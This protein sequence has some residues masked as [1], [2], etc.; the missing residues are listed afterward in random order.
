MNAVSYV[1]LFRTKRKARGHALKTNICSTS[2]LGIS[3]KVTVAEDTDAVFVGLDFCRELNKQGF[4]AVKYD[5][6]AYA[7][8]EW[9]MRR[10]VTLTKSQYFSLR[11][12][13]RLLKNCG[14]RKHD[15]LELEGFIK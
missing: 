6:P 12:P 1:I 15:R 10:E 8:T 7:A 9:L 3:H 4:K 5:V 11:V 2:D 13:D 14:L